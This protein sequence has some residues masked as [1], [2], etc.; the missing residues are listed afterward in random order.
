LKRK[1][2]KRKE[3]ELEQER[4]LKVRWMKKQM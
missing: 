3:E 2:L 4:K 1:N